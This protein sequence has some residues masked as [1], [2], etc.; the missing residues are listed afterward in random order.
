M[1]Y[2]PRRRCSLH[3]S[4]WRSVDVFISSRPASSVH[5]F[6][7]SNVSCRPSKKAKAV[8][9]SKQPSSKRPI[10]ADITRPQ[11][12]EGA[13]R[14]FFES[15]CRYQGLIR[16]A[17][18]TSIAA[19]MRVAAAK[20]DSGV[21]DMKIDCPLRH[22]ELAGI[23]ADDL[24]RATHVSAPISRSFSFSSSFGPTRRLPAELDDRGHHVE[25]DRFGNVVVGSKP[26]SLELVISS[27]QCGEEHEWDMPEAKADLG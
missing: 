25:I 3:A 21:V 17:A 6:Q 5:S 1:R 9:P 15:A 10:F 24:P 16:S 23:C 2:R 27:G 13:G 19:S 7:N 14:A 22:P 18:A 4:K 26:T 20:L 8:S 11:W 12:R